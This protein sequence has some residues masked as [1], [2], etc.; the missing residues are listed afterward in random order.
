MTTRSFVHFRCN[1]VAA[2]TVHSK[3]SVRVFGPA[4][5]WFQNC[6]VYFHVLFVYDVLFCFVS[7][8]I[9]FVTA[10][11]MYAPSASVIRRWVFESE[12]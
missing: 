6:C 4:I 10:V 5:F 3:G 1:I 11:C 8:L 12:F 2:S 7:T 9:V